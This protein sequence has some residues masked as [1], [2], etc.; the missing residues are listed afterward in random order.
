MRFMLLFTLFTSSLFVTQISAQTPAN[1]PRGDLRV[2]LLSDFN[3]SYGVTSYSPAV[4]RVTE[5]TI[6]VWQPDLF[7]SAGDVVAGQKASLPDTRFAE[8]WEAFDRAVARPLRDAGI[9]YAFAV[10]NHDGSSLRRADGNFVYAREREAAGA[11]WLEPQHEERLAY[12]DKADFPFNYSFVF[13]PP[14][15]SDKP[16]F[17]LVWDASSATI[18]EAQRA[19]AEGELESP[20]AREAA[21]RL[22]V[23][24]LPLYGVSAEKNKPGEVLA[25]GDALR[26]LLER[27]GVHTYVSGHHAAY[28]PGKR[29]ALE[30]L[31]TGGVGARQ[32]LG[33]DAPPRSTVTVMDVNF[34]PLEVRHTTF[35]VFSFDVIPLESLPERLNGLNGAVIRRDR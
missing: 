8:M 4:A 29:G 9:P 28:F 3:G 21:L 20:A 2:V 18:T 24:H 15:K 13:T 25:D 27:H 33:S 6:Q 5:T 32:L 12:H 19:W 17:I 31:H 14:D 23:G 26:E 16:V 30:L 35:D 11:Y 34:E 1:P 22:V 7:L 10:G